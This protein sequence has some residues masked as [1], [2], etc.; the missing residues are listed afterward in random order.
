[1]RGRKIGKAIWRKGER[2]D[3]SEGHDKVLMGWEEMEWSSVSNGE[4]SP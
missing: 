4:M 2:A 1:M 3:V